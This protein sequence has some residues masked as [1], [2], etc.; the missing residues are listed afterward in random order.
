MIT[1]VRAGSPAAR[2]GLTAGARLLRVN[3]NPVRD[4]LDYRFYTCDRKLNIETAEPSGELRKIK[5]IHAPGGDLGLVFETS[6]MDKPRRCQNSCVFC[7]IDQQPKN[8]R[9]TLYFKDDDFRLSFMQGNYITLTNLD[10]GDIDRIIEQR[11]SPARV[12]VHATDPAAR[13]DMLRNP[14]A[15]F[16]LDILRRLA[17]AG[18]VLHAQIVICP[19]FNDGDI[20]TRTLKDLSALG[21]ESVSV[22]PAGLTRYREG[23][24][25]IP[26]VTREIALDCIDRCEK[27]MRVYCA[28]ELFL[29]AGLPIP[30]AVYYDGYPQLENGVGMARSFIDDFMMEA[31]GRT[32]RRRNISVATGTAFAPIL[33]GLAPAVK[34][35]A[36]RNEFWGETVN[37]AG[38][39]VGADL[40]SQLKDA[41]LGELL[42]IP[43][44]MLRNGGDV[45]L[46]GLTPADVS[47]ELGVDIK[48]VLPDGLALAR[49]LY[50]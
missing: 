17:D 5:L 31:E 50:M 33:R 44:N 9:P 32:P 18:I 24:T 49:E 38:L 3:G 15:G 35:Y 7:F 16:C 22:V 30:F 42:L 47:R 23:L 6:L 12:S 43:A 37:A 48:A 19:G 36:V 2:A 20:L 1:G 27:F 41:D 26:P 45:F 4:V 29:L 25:H 11:L 14:R 8:M 40:I 13:F 10:D 46:D 39:I 21:C 34:V 28:D